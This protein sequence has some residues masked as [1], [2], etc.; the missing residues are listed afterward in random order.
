MTLNVP[1]PCP[2]CHN[3]V[4]HVFPC[5]FRLVCVNFSTH[6]LVLASALA[7][8]AFCGYPDWLFRAIRHPVVWLGTLLAGLDKRLNTP[9]AHARRAKGL[10][11]LI[12]LILCAVVPCL[13]AQLW[14][15]WPLVAVL[16]ASLPAQRSLY[17]H[18]RAV[19]RGLET[20][21]EEGRKAVSAIVGRDPTSLN[22]AAV[23]RAA[24]ESLAENFS[25][26]IVAPAFWCALAG[27]PG[28]AAYKAINTA[29]SMIGHRSPR[30]QLFGWA[31]AR[32][33]DVVNVPASRLSALWLILAAL[34]CGTAGQALRAVARDARHHRSPN[35]G[36]PEAAMAGALGLRLAGPRIY[37]GV[38]VE[39]HWM[40]HGTDQATPGDVR[41]GLAL[42]RRAC[43]LQFLSVV[44]LIVWF[45]LR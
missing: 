26:G 31:A 34:P 11:C 4:R 15:P 40:G 18:V 45:Q 5:P 39:D 32:L 22:E 13:L 24:I 44:G 3:H 42:Y 27:L 16:A 30:Y 38:R 43:A 6:L 1:C 14:L 29:D 33:D 36:W 2:R 25:D 9:T 35:A 17:V 20:G 10:V 8:E 19:A 28:M 41:R 12:I 21:L 23:A 37:N 7:L